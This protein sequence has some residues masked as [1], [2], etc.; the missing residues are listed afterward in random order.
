MTPRQRTL[1]CPVSVL[2]ASFSACAATSST[3]AVA[4]DPGALLLRECSLQTELACTE[5]GETVSGAPEAPSGRLV[6]G[7]ADKSKP[8]EQAEAVDYWYRIE[9]VVMAAGGEPA[10]PVVGARA[11]AAMAELAVLGVDDLSIDA[12]DQMD[13]AL[14]QAQT[15][16]EKVRERGEF[17]VKWGEPPVQAKGARA[18]AEAYA[19]QAKNFSKFQLPEELTMTARATLSAKRDKIAELLR[20]ERD[21]LWEGLMEHCRNHAL[22]DGACSDVANGPEVGR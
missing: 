1:I 9:E 21:L 10:N 5:Y 22:I 7:L 4:E 15:D 8:M 6:I 13:Q 12:T 2:F 18:I 3:P 20:S 11:A 14:V 16:L 17:A 19:R